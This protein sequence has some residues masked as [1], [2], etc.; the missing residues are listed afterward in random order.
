MDRCMGDWVNRLLIRL[1]IRRMIDKGTEFYPGIVSKPMTCQDSAFLPLPNF[2]A[3]T[4]SQPNITVNISAP[5]ACGICQPAQ[6]EPKEHCGRAV[7]HLWPEVLHWGHRE[8]SLDHRT[9]ALWNITRNDSGFYQCESCN[10]ATSSIG[11]PVL[12]KVICELRALLKG[13]RGH[14]KSVAEG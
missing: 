12:I 3:E 6:L 14:H 8:L 10:S 2:P 13:G 1:L 7:V 4:L 5:G 9:L 11:N